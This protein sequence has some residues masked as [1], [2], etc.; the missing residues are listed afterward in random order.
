[1]LKDFEDEGNEFS[2]VIINPPYDL[3]LKIGDAMYV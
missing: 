2:Y 3:S 1:M